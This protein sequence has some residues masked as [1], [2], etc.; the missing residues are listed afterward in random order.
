M[1]S[2]LDYIFGHCFSASVVLFA[3]L[4]NIIYYVIYKLCYYFRVLI[5]VSFGCAVSVLLNFYYFD[6]WIFKFEF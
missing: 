2:K 3:L 4:V 5:L 6:R 1:S